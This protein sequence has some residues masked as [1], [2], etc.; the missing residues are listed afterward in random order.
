MRSK[1]CDWLNHNNPA[2]LRNG[3]AA[4]LS[5]ALDFGVCRT[6]T[7][8]P[9]LLDLDLA[10]GVFDLLLEFF[11]LVLGSAF[12]EGLRGGLDERLRLGEAQAGD[13][14]DDLD[15][16]DLRGGVEA[17]EDDVEVGLFLR[18]GRGSGGGSSPL[19]WL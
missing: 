19:R 16:L 13:L 10:A 1:H 7:R 11:R 12:L 5:T 2:A 8:Q 3:S 15:D 18:D 6:E 14:A 4:G 17:G 9:C